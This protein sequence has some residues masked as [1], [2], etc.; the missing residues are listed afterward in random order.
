MN[1]RNNIFWVFLL[2][3]LFTSCGKPIHN[4]KER[5]VVTSKNLN[6]RIDP[7]SLSRTIGTLAKGDTITALAADKYWIMVKVGNQTGFVSN[8]YLKKLGP[9]TLPKILKIVEL[10]ADWKVWQ[11]WMISVLLIIL[12]IT[13]ELGL[14]RYESH[15]KSTYK[16]EVKKISVTPLI[17]FVTAVISG[18]L[19]LYWKEQ[20][21]ESLFHD[22]S[23]F[24]KGG[25]GSIA[26]IIWIQCFVVIVGMIIDYI[27]SLYRSGVKYGHITFLMEQVIN[28]LIFTVTFYLTI[29]AF[30]ASIIF[31][32]IF[33]SILYTLIVTE[34]SK[35]LTEIIGGKEK[36]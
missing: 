32:V 11:F 35:S 31:L 4:A 16:V 5:Y 14:M 1:F 36:N 7:T 20:I 19:Y 28:L 34:N 13:S 27:G 3:F 30:V 12:W 6:I 25:M 23:I 15:L 8:E 24:P 26:W 21:I 9:V 29:S 33:F 22:V 2:V 10:N 18:V 17:I